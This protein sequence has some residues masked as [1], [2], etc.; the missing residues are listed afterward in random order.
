[1]LVPPLKAAWRALWLCAPG[2]V[3]P[4]RWTAGGPRRNA[5]LS[6]GDGAGLVWRS[7]QKHGIA[8]H[9]MDSW[10]SW[11]VEVVSGGE[12]GVVETETSEGLPFLSCSPNTTN[13]VRY[14]V[15][16]SLLHRYTF[17]LQFDHG[18]FELSICIES[19]FAMSTSGW[20]A[21]GMWG[22]SKGSGPTFLDG[23]LIAW[24]LFAWQSETDCR[25]II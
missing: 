14:H 12:E 20:D 11:E 2:L 9:S 23:L 7:S 21:S 22:S 18:E 17:E 1:M 16:Y 4:F 10:D 25:A 13:H 5:Q 3:G 19:R 15:S 8:W 24:S 6:R